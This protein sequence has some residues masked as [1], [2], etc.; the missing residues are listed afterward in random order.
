MPKGVKI[1]VSCVSGSGTS[2]MMRMAVEKAAKELGMQVDKIHHC[3]I[4]EGKSTASQYDI[5]VVGLN[6]VEMFKSAQDSGTTVIGLKNVLS[7]DEAKE[8][9]KE[10]DFVPK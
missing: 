8:K 6:F 10:T 3:S 9:L 7:D 1:I 5:A 4:S 2:M